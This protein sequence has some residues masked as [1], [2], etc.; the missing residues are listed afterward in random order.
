MRP[1]RN[2]PRLRKLGR[3][4]RRLGD[5]L[6]P[7]PRTTIV[8]ELGDRSITYVDAREI[9]NKINWQTRTKP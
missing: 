2:R 3:L 7:S 4:L 1:I 6:D 5:R 8:I 9:A